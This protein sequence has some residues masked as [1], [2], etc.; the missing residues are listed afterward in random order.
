MAFP[1]RRHSKTSTSSLSVKEGGEIS[2]AFIAGQCRSFLNNLRM[3][4]WA[5]VQAQVR[6]RLSSDHSQH[7]SR[8]RQSSFE[9]LMRAQDFDYHAGAQPLVTQAYSDISGPVDDGQ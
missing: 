4:L 1:G 7:A 2:L 3:N 5:V 6:H 9:R 8:R